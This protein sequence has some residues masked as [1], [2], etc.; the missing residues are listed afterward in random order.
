MVCFI[1][2]NKTNWLLWS[3][4]RV[5]HPLITG[6]VLEPPHAEVPLGKCCYRCVCVCEGERVSVQ[7]SG[8]NRLAVYLLITV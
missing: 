8:K 5:C 2:I 6:L 4:C 3:G 7:T 1:L